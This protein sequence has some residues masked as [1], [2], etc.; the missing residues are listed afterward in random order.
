MRIFYSTSSGLIMLPAESDSEPAILG[1]DGAVPD[2]VAENVSVLALISDWQDMEVETLESAQDDIRSKY[3]RYWA[4]Q[5][6]GELIIGLP[7]ALERDTIIYLDNLLTSKALPHEVVGDLL[8]APLARTESARRLASVAGGL[9]YKEVAKALR[10]LVEVQ[11][12]LSTLFSA[13][14]SLSAE[15]FAALG[16]PREEL[17]RRLVDKGAIPT[18]LAAP[19][20][21]FLGRWRRFTL[22]EFRDSITPPIRQALQNVGQDLERQ[23]YRKAP[24]LPAIAPDFVIGSVVRRMGELQVYYQKH[25]EYSYQGT[26]W[27]D[28]IRILLRSYPSPTSTLDQV[29]SASSAP[30]RESSPHD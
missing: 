26:L 19:Q 5:L 8:Q 6:L 18:L 30:N 15:H 12:R 16:L 17:W 10:A 27:D 14:R 7:S 1:V 2:S 11:P 28:A 25:Y 9:G 13:W 24:K 20:V 21:E 4:A 29:D 22:D 3:W 23:L